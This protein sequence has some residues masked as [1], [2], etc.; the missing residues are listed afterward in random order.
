MLTSTAASSTNTI[1][2]SRT[3]F[4]IAVLLVVSYAQHIVQPG[5]LTPEYLFYTPACATTLRLIPS[6]PTPHRADVP[7]CVL[8]ILYTEDRSY[9]IIGG[10]HT[11]GIYTAR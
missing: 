3:I 10:L 7:S 1:R 2:F 4:L 6:S 5:I 9:D 11:L 8:C